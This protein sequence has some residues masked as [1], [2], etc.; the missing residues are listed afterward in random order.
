MPLK[1]YM[2]TEC[3]GNFFIL[4]MKHYPMECMQIINKV[5]T[6]RIYKFNIMGMMS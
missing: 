4:E 1:C 3:S 2:F 6:I 5:F